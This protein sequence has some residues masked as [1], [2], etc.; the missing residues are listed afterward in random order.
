MHEVCMQANVCT[1]GEM[2]EKKKKKKVHALFHGTS[3]ALSRRTR[4]R[5]VNYETPLDTADREMSECTSAANLY[6]VICIC[7]H[8]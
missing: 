3:S 7:A 8:G 4:S 1:R 6:C 2:G 5:H